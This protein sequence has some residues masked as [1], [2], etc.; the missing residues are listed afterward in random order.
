MRKNKSSRLNLKKQT[1]EESE[2]TVSRVLLAP[3]QQAS[4][5]QRSPERRRHPLRAGLAIVAGRT[6]GALSRRLRLGGGTSV[7]GLV[8]QRVYPEIIEHLA[9]QLEYGCVI[10]TGTNGKTTTSSFI[11]SI[12]STA[13]LRVLHNKEGSNLMRGIATAFVTRASPIGH[14]DLEKK[15]QGIS[16]LEIDEA[17]L[18]Q[19]LQAVTPRIIVFNNLFRDQLDRYGEV[20]TV[21]S[22]W[23]KAIATLPTDTILV[24]NA[25]DPTIANLSD[26]FAGKIIYYGINDLSLN[27]LTQEET[28]ERHQVIDTRACP[29]CGSEYL[30]DARFYSHMGHYRCPNGHVKR[31]QP[32]VRAEHIHSESF[33]RLRVQITT[34]SQEKEVVIPLP[35]LYNIYNALAAITAAQALSINWEPILNGIEQFKP[36]FGRG[37]SIQVEGRMLRLLLAKNPTGFNEVLRTLFS[38]NTSRHVLFIL[39]D[40]IADGQDVSW[41]WDVD[42]ERAVGNTATLTVTGT[43]ARDLA[44]RMKYAGVTLENMQVIPSQPLR[45]VK[46]EKAA[47]KEKQR[48]ARGIPE[49]LEPATSTHQDHIYGLKN[50]ID[51]ALQRVPVGETLFIVPTYTGLLEIHRELE[52]RGLTAHYWEGRDA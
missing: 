6:A 27:L 22:R 3:Q 12:L 21:A 1:V 14:L 33:D 4:K 11:A 49:T 51:Q 36:V 17:T 25:D 32:D 47:K 46:N 20:D 28:I 34:D 30:Y 2:D 48:L 40:R 41:I 16:V 31:P 44:L 42:F 18:P 19:A 26:G 24:L 8:A 39:N 43:R 45:T 13:G 50:A 37:E 52:Q 38:D 9:T 10:V 35:G 23:R 29:Y 7:V 5:S 15:G